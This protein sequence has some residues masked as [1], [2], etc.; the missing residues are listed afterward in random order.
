ML[1]T[2]GRLGLKDSQLLALMHI[3]LF[4]HIYGTRII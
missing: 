3:C 2:A 1:A 4:I